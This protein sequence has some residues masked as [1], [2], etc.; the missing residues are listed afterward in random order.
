[1]EVLEEA[2]VLV[3]VLAALLAT[4]LETELQELQTQAAAA[5]VAVKP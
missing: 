3:V 5:V 1:V 2:Q 4:P